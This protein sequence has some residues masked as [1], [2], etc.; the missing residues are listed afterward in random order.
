MHE[1]GVHQLKQFSIQSALW[2]DLEQQDWRDVLAIEAVGRKRFLSG[3]NGTA[4]G[5]AA[6]D[7]LRPFFALAHAHTGDFVGAEAL[8]A[9]TAGDNDDAVR[10]RALI[11]EMDGNHAR[12][13]WWFLRSEAQ[14]PSLP[15]TDALWGDALLKRGQPD[16]AIGKFKLSNKK[17]PHFADPLEGWGEAL[18]A[19]NQSRQA[20]VKFEEANKYAPNWGRLHLKWGEALAYSGKTDPAKAQ[21]T[22]AAQLD[23]VPADRAELARMNHG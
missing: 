21:F 5:V 10:A 4:A 19:K 1:L 2:L 20:L 23:L 8:I 11:A 7:R 12:A 3:G 22:R 6:F 15:F 13:D 14:T 9:P 18:I 17:G 16:A